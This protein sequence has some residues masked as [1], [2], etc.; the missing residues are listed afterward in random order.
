MLALAALLLVL[1]TALL[2]V[3][4][5]RLPSMPATAKTARPRRPRRRDA[6]AQTPVGTVLVEVAARLR[7]GASVQAAWRETCERYQDV[8]G[9]LRELAG[10]T[11]PG[12][13]GPGAPAA[14]AGPGALASGASPRTDAVAGAV[15][16]VR[17]AERLGA[18]LADVLESCAH[19]VAEAEEAAANRRTALAAPRATARLLAWLPLA[20][21]LL[22]LILGVDPTG[23][24]LDG[25]WGTVSMALGLALMAAGHRWTGALVAAAERAG[26]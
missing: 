5:R 9:P 24:F 1:A 4:G 19:G 16:A 22:G 17:M 21:V 13:I 7:T 25:S 2:T 14:G 18:P 8:P 15:A 10:T 3:P 6:R 26:R 12:V 11:G 23:V 20:G